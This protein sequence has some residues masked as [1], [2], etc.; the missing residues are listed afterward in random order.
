MSHDEIN[1]SPHSRVNVTY[2]E[3]LEVPLNPRL[4]SKV[5][6]TDL[7]YEKVFFF[8]SSFGLFRNN[9]FYSVHGDQFL[10]ERLLH[11]RS[12]VSSIIK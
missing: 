10:P 12:R 9:L 8:F 2:T 1:L 3:V 6:G 7:N 5:T 11:R 4:R